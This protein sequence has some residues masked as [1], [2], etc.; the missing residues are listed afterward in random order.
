MNF[1]VTVHTCFE[2]AKVCHYLIGVQQ[3]FFGARDSSI[4]WTGGHRESGFQNCGKRDEMHTRYR[5]FLNFCYSVNGK[6]IKL[7]CDAGSNSS[8][9]I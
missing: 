9:E 7:T 5:E 1:K 8:G 2:E 3:A 6:D 4:S